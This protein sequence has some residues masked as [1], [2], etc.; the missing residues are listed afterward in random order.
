M[1]CSYTFDA[2]SNP[3]IFVLDDY[4]AEMIEKIKTELNVEEKMIL[5]SKIE[6]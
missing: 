2:G 6:I 4:R 5:S 1:V 3:F